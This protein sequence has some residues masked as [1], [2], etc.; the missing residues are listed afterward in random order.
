[1]PNVPSALTES[2]VNN[3]IITYMSKTLIFTASH[4]AHISFSAPFLALLPSHSLPSFSLIPQIAGSRALNYNNNKSYLCMRTVKGKIW[5]LFRLWFFVWTRFKIIISL[6]LSKTNINY[7]NIKSPCHAILETLDMDRAAASEARGFLPSC[8]T[9]DPKKLWTYWQISVS[10]PKSYAESRWE[11][12]PYFS[13]L[14]KSSSLTPISR[15]RLVFENTGKVQGQATLHEI[16][17]PC[18]MYQRNIQIHRLVE[19]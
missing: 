14:Q 12:L 6:P 5:G 16:L 18:I 2:T 4:E 10:D 19:F 8:Q 15:R 11:M 7:I 13:V 1:M 17:L 9:V 3:Q